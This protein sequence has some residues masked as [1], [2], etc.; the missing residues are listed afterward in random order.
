VIAEGTCMVRLLQVLTRFYAHES[1]GQCTPCREGTAWMNDILVRILAGK[2]ERADLDN[3]RAVP[4]GILG[5]TVCALGDAAAIP[6]IS[7]M[8]KFG[9]EFEYFVEHGRS[10]YDGRLE[11]Q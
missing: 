3:L 6:V 7:F 11:V 4:E 9:S 2:G 8:R 5:K 1:C 10:R